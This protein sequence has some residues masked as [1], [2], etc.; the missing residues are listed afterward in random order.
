MTDTAQI[1]SQS[2]TPSAQQDAVTDAAVTVGT[3][4]DKG[5]AGRNVFN[6]YPKLAIVT[7]AALAI[8]LLATAYLWRKLN[9]IQ[10]H[11]ARQSADASTLSIEARS[12]AKNAQ[13]LAR[14]AMARSSLNETKLSE[15]ALQRSQLDEL[16]QSLSRSRDENLVVDIESAL[17]L[18]QQQAQ[19]TGSVEPLL[20]ALKTADVRL[21]KSAQPR[22]NTV[23]RALNNDALRIKAAT[24]T[25]VPNLMGKLDELTQLID[26]LPAGNAVGPKSGDTAAS[27]LAKLENGQASVSHT[28]KESKP[29]KTTNMGSDLQNAVSSWVQRVWL[30]VRA[31]SGKLVRVSQIGHPDAVLQTP[32]QTFFLR[33]NLKLRVLNARMGVLSRQF[34]SAKS[35]L[36]TVNTDLRKY[37]DAGTPAA[38]QA[39]SLLQQSQ[40]QLANLSIPGLEESLAALTVA[41][42]GR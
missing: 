22:L 8:S 11:L 4:S 2:D 37:A 10:E 24:V 30:A 42:A 32:E 41:A 29:A 18:A 21:A 28:G 39:F 36:A 31:E 25:D 5:G 26:T 40:A 38:K 19:L 27:P 14:D 6:Q 17:R 33:E 20:A 1:P 9:G 15:V 13:E 23:R 35:D 3:D 34:A 16:M 7:I 12:L